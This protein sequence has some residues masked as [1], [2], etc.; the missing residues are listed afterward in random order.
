MKVRQAFWERQTA[1]HIWWQHCG[2]AARYAV[3]PRQYQWFCAYSE[4]CFVCQP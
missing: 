2:R 3:S 4:L 1:P